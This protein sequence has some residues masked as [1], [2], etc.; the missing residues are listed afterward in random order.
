MTKQ[1]YQKKHTYNGA[2]YI[3]EGPVSSNFLKQCTFHQ[4]L[5]S[6]R[7]SEQQHQAIIKATKLQESRI[8]IA[9]IDKM[10]VGYIAFTYPDE[11]E[12]WSKGKMED[13]LELGAIEVAIPYRG[14]GLA[15][16]ML[17]IALK[18]ITM[19]KFIV[20]TT[21]HYWHWDLKN[22]NLNIWQYQDM[23]KKVLGYFGFKKYD[24]ID[25]EVQSDPANLLMARI[26]EKVPESSISTFNRLRCN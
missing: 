2:E 18:D 24:T 8:I 4:D 21:L 12:H 9:R 6:F 16:E 15:K 5:N 1:F 10:I 22:T 14:M 17:Q 3:V 23:M 7:I 26:G 20:I 19:E 13:L 11:L 25:P